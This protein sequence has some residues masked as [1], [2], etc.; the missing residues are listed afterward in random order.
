MDLLTSVLVPLK[1]IPGSLDS[2]FRVLVLTGHQY[3]I[4]KERPGAQQVLTEGPEI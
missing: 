4:Q 3:S 1:Y 2:S